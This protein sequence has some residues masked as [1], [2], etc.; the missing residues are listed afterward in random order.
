M[1][2]IYFSPVPWVSFAQRP[3]KFVEWFH[4]RTGRHVL[5]ID[6]YPTRLPKLSDFGRVNLK[7][8]MANA[9]QPEWLHILKPRAFPIEPLP[10][11]GAINGLLWRNILNKILQF[12]EQDPSMIAVAKP[13]ELALRVLEVTPHVL[14][15]YDGM[16]DF[17][18]FYGGVSRNS[19]QN[20]LDMISRV[21]DR[22]LVS[23]TVLGENFK[24]HH[25][26][27]ASAFN[28]C[29]L[30]SLPEMD[31]LI[32]PGY[33]SGAHVIGYVGTIGQW[34]DWPLVIRIAHANPKAI[35]RLI[36]PVYD[37]PPAELPGNIELLPPCSHAQA[38]RYMCDFS[39]GLIPFKKN[40]LTDA[41]DPIKYY[42]YK[43]IGLPVITTNFGEMRFR[44]DVQGVFFID[45]EQ[46]LDAL[47]EMACSF[48]PDL[49]EIQEFR[50]S[51][52]WDMRFDS[53]NL[54]S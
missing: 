13:S 39:A 23:S 26:K 52:N 28:A 50:A 41:V 45:C 34:F 33:A 36:G 51:N 11:S 47:V 31:G 4:K 30:Q 37:S 2:L 6:P 7:D 25:K 19:M 5:W 9:E 24:V 43:A 44:N 10:G 15:V 49:S 18:L 38:I 1:R 35:V 20:R 22:I 12:A 32:K 42:E 8:K 53:C 3:Q 46:P 21:V 48:R 16:D 14:S 54:L 40:P 29:D 27:V 17:P